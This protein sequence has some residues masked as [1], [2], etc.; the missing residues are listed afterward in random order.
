LAGRHCRWPDRAGLPGVARES[1][2]L[3]PPSTTGKLKRD[4]MELN[5]ALF[6]HPA[7]LIYAGAK[8]ISRTWMMT[9][10]FWLR[11]VGAGMGWRCRR[12]GQFVWIG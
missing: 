11:L 5:F 12:G 6:Q 7:N 8:Y 4:I 3:Q 9:L 10:A 2:L 1:S